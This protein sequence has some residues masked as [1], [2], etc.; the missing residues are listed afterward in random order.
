MDGFG[1]TGGAALSPGIYRV[2]LLFDQNA[3]A[4]ASRSLRI[5]SAGWRKELVEMLVHHLCAERLLSDLAPYSQF[6]SVLAVERPASGEAAAADQRL[7]EK[8][9]RQG[10]TPHAAML[11]PKIREGLQ[12][13]RVPESGMVWHV[14]QTM[15]VR[16]LSN[17]PE[18]DRLIEQLLAAILRY[19]I[20]P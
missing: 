11:T 20:Q 5:V 18:N 10:F 8:K 16:C 2:S 7:L 1:G 14:W 13:L 12:T 4:G 6:L 9:W 15:R 3:V 17:S 19:E